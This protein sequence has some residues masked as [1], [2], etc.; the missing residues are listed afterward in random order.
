MSVCKVKL[1][2]EYVRETKSVTVTWDLYEVDAGMTYTATQ[3]Y[4]G[5]TA[6]AS[7]TVPEQTYK[8]VQTATVAEDLMGGEIIM[9]LFNDHSAFFMTEVTGGTL[10]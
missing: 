10:S 9:R 2:V 7:Y 8:V 6:S 1:T 3:D 5:G 4:E